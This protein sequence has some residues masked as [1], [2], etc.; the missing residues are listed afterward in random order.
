MKSNPMFTNDLNRAERRTV[1]RLTSPA[2]IQTYLDELAY[3]P[4]DDRY[5]CPLTVV[6]EGLAHCFEAAVFGAAA[7]RQ[8][9]YRPLI[10]NLFPEPGTDDEH[11]LA[12]YGERCA[13]GA[14]AKSNYA[15][16]RYREPIHRS[17]RELVV[18]YF[19]QYYNLAKD[20]TLR[21]Y[22]RPL[23]LASFDRYDWLAQDD[24]MTLIEER[25]ELDAADSPAHSIHD[26]RAVP[27]GRALLSLGPGRLESGR[28]IPPAISSCTITTAIMI[29]R[30]AGTHYS[31]PGQTVPERDG[32]RQPGHARVPRR[33]TCLR[34]EPE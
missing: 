27:G 14:V 19:E 17:L 2:R 8:I 15:G 11:L 22:S 10:V 3:N 23:N 18:S 33:A 6:R 7:L 16:L 25:S 4:G 29:R 20:K 26:P 5:R 12:I 31:G 34:S 32:R 21:S 13:W 9:G 1:A 24:T 30:K 28:I